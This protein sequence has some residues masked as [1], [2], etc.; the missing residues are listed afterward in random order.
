MRIRPDRPGFGLVLATGWLMLGPGAAEAALSPYWQSVKEIEAIVGDQRVN[1]ALKYEEA[2][3]SIST[4][5]NDVYEV[6]TE[7]CVL[8]VTIVDV[9]QEK[10][11][12]GPRQFDLD[13]GT[14]ACQ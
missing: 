8:R 13:V 2:I 3:L 11:V 7:R 4:T 9:P 6:R 12:M 14:A 5:G 1:D 10:P